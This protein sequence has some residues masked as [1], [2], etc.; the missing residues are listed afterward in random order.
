MGSGDRYRMD[1]EKMHKKYQ[2]FSITSQ[3]ENKSN[4]SF[5]S[6]HLTLS[7]VVHLHMKSNFSMVS[8][9]QMP[10]T[11]SMPCDWSFA[12]CRRMWSNPRKYLS[13]LLVVQMC[14]VVKASK[15]MT[16]TNSMHSM[17][18]DFGHQKMM[19]TSKIPIQLRVHNSKL[20]GTVETHWTLFA[21]IATIRYSPVKYNKWEW[22]LKKVSKSS[23]KV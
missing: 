21:E 8:F 9:A 10:H 14:T 23:D 4:L 5:L 15:S 6:H 7:A 17:K 11:N 22:V 19:L 2:R 18:W 13:A 20:A 12:H 3:Y 1:G 16:L